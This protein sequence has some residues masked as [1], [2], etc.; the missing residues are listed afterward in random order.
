MSR[1]ELYHVGIVVRNIEA[2]SDRLT[3]L[4]GLEWGPIMESE[5]QVR[6]GEGTDFV[7]PNRARYSTQAPYLELIEEKPGTVWVRNPYSNR[8]HIGF[9]TSDLSGEERA[10]HSLLCP[11]EIMGRSGHSAPI[12]FTYH[13]DDDLGVRI[14]HV[15]LS[16]RESLEGYAFKAL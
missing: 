7:L 16:L 8:H 10:L 4:L 5:L 6:D 11:L 13:R 12:T 9:F 15:D 14:E 3:S 2:A 1:S